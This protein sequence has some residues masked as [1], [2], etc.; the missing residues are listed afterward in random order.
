MNHVTLPFTPPTSGLLLVRLRANT[1]GRAYVTLNNADSNIADGYQVA[2]GFL[3]TVH[4]V[5]GGQEVSIGTASNVS[6]Q[7]YWFVSLN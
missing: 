2:A 6:N 5:S 7:E 1:T 3:E 4:F